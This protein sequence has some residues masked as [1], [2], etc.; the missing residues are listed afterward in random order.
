MKKLYTKEAFT[1]EL[2]LKG[3]PKTHSYDDIS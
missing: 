2:K 1:F 3:Q